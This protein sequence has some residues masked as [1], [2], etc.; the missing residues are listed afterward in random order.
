LQRQEDKEDPSIPLRNSNTTAIVKI[1]KLVQ[2]R[3]HKIWYAPN[4]KNILT[5][6]TVSCYTTTLGCAN[7]KRKEKKGCKYV[8]TAL[9]W[10]R[11]KGV[12]KKINDSFAITKSTT[13][14]LI[15]IDAVRDIV[16]FG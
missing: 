15:K 6:Q 1:K 12:T 3:L 16:C 5:C 11:E 8:H 2:N 9:L 4:R 13:W 10:L 7:T 14:P